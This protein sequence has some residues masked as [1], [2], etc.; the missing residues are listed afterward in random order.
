MVTTRETRRSARLLA[1]SVAA[2]VLA[3]ALTACGYR[4]TPSSGGQSSQA[5]AAAL[6]AVPGIDNVNAYTVPWYYSGEGSGISSTGIDLLVW[7]TIDPQMHIVDGAQFLREVGRA[8]WSI[9]DG[10][11]PQGD[12]VLIVR[13]GLDVFHDWEADAA[14][15][16]GDDA[17]L[18]SD[19]S[20]FRDY[21]WGNKPELRDDDKVL[22]LS[23]AAYERTFGAWPAAPA[24]LS[25]GLLAAGAPALEE[26]FAVANV[27]FSTFRSGDVACVNVGFTRNL[28]RDGA[29]YAGDV[30]VTLLLEGAEYGTAVAAGSADDADG[31]EWKVEFCDADA[32]TNRLGDLTAHVVAPAAPGF[33]GVDAVS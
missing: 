12:V 33:R 9:N 13:R 32:P 21:E 15:V 18:T 3:A 6:E 10:H 22:A 23:T 28:D 7:L 11:S 8:A 25:P 20:V 24:P 29:P 17:R 16:F 26:P 5:V 14:V 30:T 4:N 2:A 31:G 27:G 19:P 1:A